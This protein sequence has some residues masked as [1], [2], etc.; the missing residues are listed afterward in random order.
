MLS[1]IRKL[2]TGK[3]EHFFTL[4]ENFTIK[5]A[6]EFAIPDEIILNEL[7]ARLVLLAELKNKLVIEK[8]LKKKKMTKFSKVDE[9]LETIKKDL[10]KNFLDYTTEFSNEPLGF[11]YYLGNQL[12]FSNAVEIVQKIYQK[13]NADIGNIY[14]S[15]DVKFHEGNYYY[16]KW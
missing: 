7:K 10:E 6:V 12:I 9:L 1:R 4:P 15:L 13:E 2:L 11:V 3:N 14:N 8:P 16:W 5:E